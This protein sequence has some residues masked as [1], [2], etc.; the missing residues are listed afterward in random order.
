[1]PRT[2]TSTNGGRTSYQ[3]RDRK[4]LPHRVQA[5]LVDKLGVESVTASGVTGV[6]EAVK[7]E[8]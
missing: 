7:N 6:C 5:F 3:V 2:S 8:Q 4:R 1:L